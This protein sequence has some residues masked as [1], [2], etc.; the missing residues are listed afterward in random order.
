MSTP[1]PR[2][3]K[4]RTRPIVLSPTPSPETSPQPDKVSKK[5]KLEHTVQPAEK[6]VIKRFNPGK[7]KIP[8][9]GRTDET[10]SAAPTEQAQTI[11]TTSHPPASALP[12]AKNDS[13]KGSR[14]GTSSQRPPSPVRENRPVTPTNAR[15]TT[16]SRTPRKRT[17]SAY[18]VTTPGKP[19]DENLPPPPTVSKSAPTTPARGQPRKSLASAPVADQTPSSVKPAQS[20]SAAKVTKG[21]SSAQTTASIAAP[22]TSASAIDS[23]ASAATGP[24]AIAPVTKKM[25]TKASSKQS[26]MFITSKSARQTKPAERPAP[27]REEVESGKSR[28][29]A[30]KQRVLDYHHHFGEVEKL[31]KGRA[32]D[33]AKNV[34]GSSSG[35]G[36]R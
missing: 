3:S 34:S 16:P 33:L 9:H 29:A 32:R 2:T 21:R 35:S 17:T 30:A 6:A 15:P 31:Q 13:R 20:T 36:R 23:A 5:A 12:A 27:A 7:A 8:R 24:K 18:N 11:S 22:S 1:P 19:D 10:A 4:K 28:Q 26:S 25:R 14:S